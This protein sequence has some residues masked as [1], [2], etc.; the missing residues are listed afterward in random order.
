MSG[1]TQSARGGPSTPDKCSLH[2][3]ALCQ[4]RYQWW[5]DGLVSAFRGEAPKHPVLVALQSVHQQMQQQ[6]RAG[7]AS[8]ESKQAATE[9]SSSGSSSTGAGPGAA[10]PAAARMSGGGTGAAAAA[11]ST[12]PTLKQ[13]HLKRMI[14]TREQD[15]LDS[16]PPL[17]VEG[18]EKYAEGTAS[19]VG[20]RLGWGKR[21]LLFKPI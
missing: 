14:D 2:N 11:A 4:V 15:M 18:L 3:H 16:Q 8:S 1:P 20:Q 21:S 7:S 13:Y 9:A 12:G 19:Q 17:S 5:R 6:R 10:S